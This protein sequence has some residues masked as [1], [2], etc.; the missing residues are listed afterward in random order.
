M[1]PLPGARP[2]A[3]VPPGLAGRA[4]RRLLDERAAAAT[5]RRW[6]VG[7]AAAAVLLGV[8]AAAVPDGEA[9]DDPFETEAADLLDL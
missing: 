4:R 9:F 7:F 8:V 2:S 3:D 5:G 6:T 1:D